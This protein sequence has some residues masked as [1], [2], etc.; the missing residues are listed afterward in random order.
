MSEAMG[1]GAR[2]SWGRLL[3]GFALW[4]G[5][6]ALVVGL[7]AGFVYRTEV[8]ADLKALKGGQQGRVD[9]VLASMARDIETAA[10]H[11][12]IL[13]RL[14]D[15]RA[16]IA[17]DT[18]ASRASLEEELLSY[19]ALTGLFDQLRFIDAAGRESVRV[20]YD[21]GRPA[22]VP[23]TALQDKS[24]RPYVKDTLRLGPGEISLSRFDL[25]LEGA[26]VERPLKPV[27]RL[28]TPIYDAAGTLRGL[29]VLN[30]LGA[31]LL[32]DLDI[33]SGGLGQMMLL[34]ADGYWLKG[35][36]EAVEWGFM[37]P[38]RTDRSFA[39]TYPDAWEHLLAADA[40]QFETADGLFT[41][42]T[43]TPLADISRRNASASFGP[44]AASPF[45]Y[46]YFW[47]VVSRIPPTALA[48]LRQ[49]R[50]T[51]ILTLVLPL[52]LVL[53]AV[54][55]VLA[56]L[57]EGRRLAIRELRRAKEAAESASRAKSEFLALMSHEIRTPMNG[58]I[59]MTELALATDLSD[60]QREYLDMSKLSAAALLTVIDDILDF[61]KI[62][63]G[64]LRL[65]RAPF[66]LRETL[67]D[68]L[69]TLA[70]RAH[71]KGIELV[72]DVP[73][74]VPDALIGDA[75]RLRQV[76]INLVG[77]AIKFTEYGE[78]V[79]AV[80]GFAPH[81][82]RTTRK[83]RAGAPA[84]STGLQFAVRDTGIGIAPDKLEHIFQAFQQ[85]DGSTTRR[86]GGTGLGLTI[87][88]RL[89]EMMGGTIWVDST[90]GGGSTFAFTA[91]FEPDTAS[92]APA[93]GAVDPAA[94]M[95]VEDNDNARRV[96]AR[97]ATHWGLQPIACAGVAEARQQLEQAAAA[98]TPP[99]VLLLDNTLADGDAVDLCE[100]IAA[101]PALQSI[102]TI[103]LTTGQLVSAARRPALGIAACLLKPVKE[104][105]LRRAVLV[106]LGAA[107]AAA[108]APAVRPAGSVGTE[109][110]G[111]RI[112]LAED[113]AVN[114]RLASRLLEK[115]GHRVTVVENGRLALDAL[116]QL[117]FDVVLMDVQMP[118]MDGLTATRELRVR[119]ADDP[120]APH[121]PV[122]A[123]TAFAM[124]DDEAMCRAAGMDGYVTKPISQPDLIAALATHVRPTTTPRAERA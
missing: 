76:V 35:P 19:A 44:S 85:A 96:L 34:D 114:Q 43:A 83:P 99:A 71:A 42:R 49:A 86:Y 68:A 14:N 24:N 23:R 2:A 84:P 112:L 74:E 37:Y 57:R 46:D 7:V 28:S 62:E 61:S 51:H 3:G 47:K 38:D 60:E 20:N 97:T 110:S 75:G 66:S 64:K 1:R 94:V 10:T 108:P 101:Q 117:S 67:G 115:R 122:I 54:A 91:R 6:G 41:F 15:L 13:A 5:A 103:L 82:Q 124:R 39:K 100:W 53:A 98:R 121:M 72:C 104:S 50:L 63:A 70:V 102:R 107:P 48:E 11:L 52:L 29:L 32:R 12:M 119:E 87:S 123:M 69:L 26:M 18:A 113:N 40:G 106:A 22:V 79:L 21:G 9:L 25:N 17:D 73:P 88:R 81:R 31:R 109:P 36:N 95:I 55:A 58:V 16:F 78:V 30:Y 93:A 45:P 56:R 65:E 77:N 89:V 105:D 8:A 120:T 90:P 59:G 111:L 4:F 118:E 92:A 116:T 80:G 27:L 33:E